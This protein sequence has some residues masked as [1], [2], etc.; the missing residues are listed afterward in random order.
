MLAE[1]LT[2]ERERFHRPSVWTLPPPATIDDATPEALAE[3]FYHLLDRSD[4]E[5]ERALRD[6]V[7]VEDELPEA[8]R[9][10]AA[11]ARLR[12]WLQLDAEDARII[13]GAY[14]R[15]VQSFPEQF[16]QRR[17]DAERAA[18]L[19]GMTFAEF[20]ELAPLLPW[21]RDTSGLEQLLEDDPE[22]QPALVTAA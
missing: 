12:A 8:R 1:T 15:A 9:Y 7:Q 19:N 6:F 5:I 2:S 13:A 11:L 20:C 17:I 16:E 4:L 10:E 3:R 18:V 14:E 22:D 21:L